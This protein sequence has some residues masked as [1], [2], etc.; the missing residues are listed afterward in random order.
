MRNFLIL[1]FCL[2]LSVNALGQNLTLSEIVA[3]RKNDLSNLDDVMTS[4]GWTL[5]N[6][7]K[8]S[9]EKYGVVEYAYQLEKY[10]DKANSFFEYYYSG[11]G[12][13][14]RV[15]IQIHTTEKFTSYMN[16]IKSWGGKLID[17][18]VE[19]NNIIKVYKGSTLT[20][21]IISSPRENKYTSNTY[22]ILIYT[23]EDYD[24]YYQ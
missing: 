23:N 22:E 12:N 6:A 17:T 13:D 5:I 20:Y 24:Y 8:P 1:L 3:L 16:Q 10:S 14:S 2:F 4:K 21:R 9:T 18:F 15:R 7:N 11:K 19:E